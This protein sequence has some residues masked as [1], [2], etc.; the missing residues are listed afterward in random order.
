[1]ATTAPSL[2]LAPHVRSLLAGLRWRIRCYVW[3][4]GIALCLA[5]LGFTFWFGLAVDFLPVLVGA[6]ELP[7]V[8]RATL[9]VATGLV[10]TWLFYRW[11]LRRVFVQLGDRSM[12]V[13]LERR[14]TFLGDSLVT[15]VEMS[16]EPERAVDFNPDML[17]LTHH[18]AIQQIQDV[19]LRQVF[20][21][22][23][24]LWKL[25]IAAAAILSISVFYATNLSAFEI[26]VRRMYLLENQPWPRRAYLEMGRIEVVSD[27]STDQMQTSRF[28]DFDKGR[29]V[30]VARGTNLRLYVNAGMKARVVPDYCTIRYETADRDRGRVNMSQMG[31]PLNGFQPYAFDGK[32]LRGILSN[33]RFD[34]IGF[35]YRIRDFQ[36]QV[37][38]RPEIRSVQLDCRFPDYIE[39]LPETGVPWTPGMQRARGS[40]VTLHFTATK[41]LQ[42]VTL[43]WISNAGANTTKDNSLPIASDGRS[44][45]FSSGVLDADLIFELTLRDTDNIYNDHPVRFVLAAVDDE[46]PRVDAQLYG[47]GSAITPRARVPFQGTAEDDY[48]IARSTVDLTLQRPPGPEGTSFEQLYHSYPFN[49]AD[50]R[51]INTELD[52][53]KLDQE[54]QVTL[55]P[56]DKLELKV[57]AQDRSTLPGAPH[58]GE[59]DAFQVDVVSDDELLK[60]LEYQ[61]LALR[62][63]FELIVGE[64]TDLRDNLVRLQDDLSVAEKSTSPTTTA[65]ETETAPGDDELSPQDRARAFRLLRIQQAQIQSRKSTQETLGVAISFEDILLQLLHN[66]IP[67]AEERKSRIKNRIAEPLREIATVDFPKLD[68]NLEQLESFQDETNRA[69]ATASD[70]VAQANMIV[71]RLESVLQEMVELETYNELIDLVRKLISDQDDLSK[72]TDKERKRRLLGPL[73]K[74]K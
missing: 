64:M 18:Q 70:T 71:S 25:T 58:R 4:E 9:L 8:A 41:H 46:A 31:R 6:S 63:R 68:N 55:L 28:L 34:V 72:E 24:L 56:G 60:R 73:L 29:S 1:M 7:R 65:P 59:S 14:F 27:N 22:P 67:K 47:I 5:W 62:Q 48:G 32:P 19:Q 42:Q 74:R 37:V 52:F 36:I 23:P 11:V 66:R 16:N 26:C 51:D 39:R 17:T 15:S 33:M 44:F 12:A 43:N 54:K 13:L 20:R 10:A 3:L 69:A 2:N 49:L 30:K 53:R 45:V 38:D 57:T 61:E 40:T 50:T 21:F 35:D